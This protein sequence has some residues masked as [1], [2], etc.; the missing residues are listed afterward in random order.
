MI[1]FDQSSTSVVVTCE[2]CPWWHGFA[3]TMPEGEASGLRHEAQVHEGTTALRD[4]LQ[5]RDRMRAMRA[6]ASM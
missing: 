2:A 5:T 3:F 4:R 6:R 1:H